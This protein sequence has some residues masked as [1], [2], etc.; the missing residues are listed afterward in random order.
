[1][2]PNFRD[3]KGKEFDGGAGS[4]HDYGK[5]HLPLFHL[6]VAAFRYHV[7]LEVILQITGSSLEGRRRGLVMM[8]VVCRSGSEKQ[9][10]DAEEHVGAEYLG[11]PG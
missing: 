10:S 5:L 11:N 6:P 4:H 9:L 7:V 2:S 8:G 3:G 1:M